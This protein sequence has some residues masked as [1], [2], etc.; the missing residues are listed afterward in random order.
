MYM[1]RKFTCKSCFKEYE[2]FGAE[3]ELP[4]RTTCSACK[5]KASFKDLGNVTITESPRGYVK[6]SP[7]RVKQ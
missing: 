7:F 1:N 2:F 6:G 5:T 4:Y 3:S